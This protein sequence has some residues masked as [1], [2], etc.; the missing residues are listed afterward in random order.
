MTTMNEDQANVSAEPEATDEI[1]PGEADFDSGEFDFGLLT[2]DEVALGKRWAAYA[3]AHPN[4]KR[5]AALRKLREFEQRAIDLP[6]V[7]KFFT[8]D[9]HDAAY[10]A[11]MVGLLAFG[12]VE[13]PIALIVLG[14]HVLVKQHQ[15][16]AMSAIGEAMED[17][18]APPIVVG[19]AIAATRPTR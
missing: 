3:A 19:G 16:R 17:C 18:L 7:G 4:S 15:S 1:G 2:A 13:L 6:V 9:T 14:G 10:V 8:P 11:G 5:I 12:A